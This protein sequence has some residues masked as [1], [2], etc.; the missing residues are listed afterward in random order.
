VEAGNTLKL[1]ENGSVL[2]NQTW[3]GVFYTDTGVD[4]PNV[5]AF[6]RDYVT[7]YGDADNSTFNDFGDLSFIFASLGPASDNDRSDVDG[8]GLVDFGD[9]AGGFNF[10]AAFDPGKPD[11]HACQ[12]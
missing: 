8:S 12:P 6:K 5:C 10:F 4:W 9:L 1:V 2:A 3:Y 7:V 11:G